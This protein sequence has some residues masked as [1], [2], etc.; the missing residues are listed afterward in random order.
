MLHRLIPFE[1]SPDKLSALSEEFIKKVGFPEKPA[2]SAYGFI[3][4]SAFAAQEAYFN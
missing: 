3:R 4:N 1:N 2:V